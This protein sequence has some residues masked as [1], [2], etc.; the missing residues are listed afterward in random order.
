MSC[1][2]LG[3]PKNEQRNGEEL[4]NC[5]INE[6]CVQQNGGRRVASCDK[7]SKHLELGSSEFIE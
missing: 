2:Y 4:F 6:Q 1:V 7:C 3:E 5:Q